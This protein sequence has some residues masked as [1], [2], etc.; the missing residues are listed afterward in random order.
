[1]DGAIT[2]EEQLE[3]KPDPRIGQQLGGYLVVARVADGAM[4]RVY[5]GRHP[6]T[7]ARVAIK[8]LHDYVAR[9]RVA[10]ERF[11]REFEAAREMNHPNIVKALEFGETAD[12]SWFMTMEYLE[13]RE[14]AKALVGKQPL[15][16]GSIVHV[17]CQVALALEHAHSFGFIHRDLKPD[18]IFLCDTPSG[19]E[20]RILDFGSVKMQMETGQKL[21]ALGT[22]LG[23]PYYM[24]PEQAMG[25]SDVD[26]RSDVFAIGAIL[27]EMVTGKVAFE[28]SSVAMILR[29][30][31][32][33]SPPPASSLN[34]ESPVALDDVIEKAIR[35]DKNRRYETA[36]A[37]AEAATAAYGLSGTI[38]SWAHRPEAEIAVAVAAAVPPPPKPFGA[39]LA[40]G[41]VPAVAA[42]ATA[43]GRHGAPAM[44]SASAGAAAV[45]GMSSSLRPAG[46][47]GNSK[48]WLGLAA[49]VL[50]AII[51]I[52]LLMK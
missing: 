48:L 31:L 27:W 3:G 12:K 45:H 28:A 37:L 2:L 25:Q 23:S 49:F 18:N 46:V 34:P 30:I 51:A 15:P 14:L 44:A 5:E 26:Q 43:G 38:E 4:G 20:V 40:P 10:V 1:M 8:V 11:K 6:E 24:S 16:K 21:T 22:T 52:V 47:G 29:K 32:S 42:P 33:E 7:K 41:A 9:D 50:V 35:K 19:V 39:S 13:G 17:V 36:R